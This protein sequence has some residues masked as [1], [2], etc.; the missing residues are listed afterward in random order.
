[1]N[2]ATESTSNSNS[3]SFSTPVVENTPQSNWE[4]ALSQALSGIGS[5]T[6]NWAQGQFDNAS[7]VTDDSIDQFNNAANTSMGVANNLIGRYQNEYEPLEDQYISEAANYASPSRLAQNM[8]AAE[9]STSQSE[10][11]NEI[12]AEQELQQYGIDPSSGRYQELV[13][14]Q[15]AGA[16]AAE[17]GAGQQAALNTE[18]TQREMEQNAIAFGQQLPGQAVNALNQGAQDVSG[19]ENSELGLSNAGVSLMDSASPY[20]NAAMSLKYPSTG[21]QTTGSSHSQQQSNG[22][23]PTPQQSGG[24]GNG[25]GNGGGSGGPASSNTPYD[26]GYGSGGGGGGGGF[27]NM[28]GSNARVAQVPGGGEDGTQ[29]GSVD[30]NSLD[31]GDNTN[32]G[33]GVDPFSAQFASN[34][35]VFDNGT[36]QSYDTANPVDPFGGGGQQFGSTQDN[37]GDYGANFSDTPSASDYAS[38]GGW[39]GSDDS[40][41]GG[42]N[43]TDGFAR[44]G[45]VLPTP[46]SRATT[47]GHV[48]SSASPS[49]G[50]QTDDISARLNAREFV[51]PQDVADWMGQKYFQDLIQKSRKAMGSGQQAPAAGQMKPPLPNQNQ[52]AFVSRHLPPA[53]VPHPGA[54]MIPQGAQ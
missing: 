24:G 33:G 29:S 23:Q 14:A 31:F 38:A 26:N 25:G 50:K 36:A 18:A 30:M 12:N 13:Q 9:S 37:S 32:V 44:G 45:G 51:I 4:L 35:D 39:G 20:F 5:Q 1:M 2:V 15:K 41:G 27:G 7:A 11:Q 17:A 28:S 48:P 46:G 43:D 10:R 8:G 3:S 34:P 16:G 19:A 49:G 6:Y 42:S 21:Q 53:G 52:P 40:S 54:G 22:N 47:G